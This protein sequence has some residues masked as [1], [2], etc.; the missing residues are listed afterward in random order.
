MLLYLC[1]VQHNFCFRCG[2]LPTHKLQGL[3]C[4]CSQMLASFSFFT[5][6][7]IAATL[8]PF[9]VN[10]LWGYAL[11]PSKS[12]QGC[13]VFLLH[14]I[15]KSLAV[16]FLFKHPNTSAKV[17]S[18]VLSQAIMIA[19]LSEYPLFTLLKLALYPCLQYFGSHLP[20]TP[21]QTGHV[22][23]GNCKSNVVKKAVFL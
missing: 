4:S 17:I 21:H 12:C 14:N 8:P 15:S 6:V 16:P 18:H 9:G 23:F 2:L 19:L 11:I 7:D 10:K 22:W 3:L 13:T 20:P 1:E 5:P